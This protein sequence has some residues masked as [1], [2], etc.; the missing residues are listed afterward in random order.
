MTLRTFPTVCASIAANPSERGVAVH[1]AGYRALGLPFTYIAMGGEDLDLDLAIK[2]MRSIGGRGL[3]VSMPFKQAII[4]L[5]TRVSEDVAS[6][7]ACNTVVFEADGSMT[8]YNT[9]W[10]GVR[11]SLAE[12]GYE[13]RRAVVVGSGGVAR[14]IA[15]ALARSGTEVLVRARN[16]TAGLFVVQDLDLFGYAPLDGSQLSGYDLI[17]NATSDSTAAGP[18]AL[19]EYP[20]AEALFDVAFTSRTTPLTVEAEAGGLKAVP[21]WRMHLH[22]A[23]QQF[24]LYTEKEPPVDLM[25]AVLAERF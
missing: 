22:Q 23:M 11:D 16:E 6:I 8:G 19:P 9:D 12:A 14:A 21:G 20:D 7:G 4:P 10:I 24:R 18:V 15:Y 17:V 13:A 3:G 2:T 25:E 5:L 1:N